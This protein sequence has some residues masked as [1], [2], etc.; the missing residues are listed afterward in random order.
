[1]KA[2]EIVLR[3]QAMRD[4]QEAVAHD[5]A[6]E[7]PQAALGLID[8][9]E[10]ALKHIGRHPATGSPRDAHEL[11]LPGLRT[12]PLRRYLHLVFYVE[13]QDHVDVWRVLHGQRDIATWL[14]APEG[15]QE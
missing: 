6:E 9:L 2:K 1:M 13:Q 11:D 4:V 10:H 7:A 15:T 5:L 3:K 8:A 12:W 14:R